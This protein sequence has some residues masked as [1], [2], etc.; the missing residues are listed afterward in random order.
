[1]RDTDGAGADVCE[2]T[3]PVA[4][5]P[6]EAPHRSRPDPF[7]GMIRRNLEE[8]RRSW[9]VREKRIYFPGHR[10]W[11]REGEAF[12]ELL[13][14]GNM[15]HVTGVPFNFASKKAR[16]ILFWEGR[17]AGLPN[18][19]PVLPDHQPWMNGLIPR[20]FKGIWYDQAQRALEIHRY[21]QY[22]VVRLASL[23]LAPEGLGGLTLQWCQPVGVYMDPRSPRAPVEPMVCRHRLCP[24]CYAR[25]WVNLLMPLRKHN[26]GG[27]HR[28][29]LTADLIIDEDHGFLRTARNWA[30]RVRRE[31]GCTTCLSGFHLAPREDEQGRLTVGLQAAWITADKPKR[32]YWPGPCGA[33][34]S[35]SAKLTRRKIDPKDSALQRALR[36]VLPYPT[37]TVALD[38]NQHF[39]AVAYMTRGQRRFSWTGDWMAEGRSTGHHHK[40]RTGRTTADDRTYGLSP[41]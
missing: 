7:E 23:G 19:D 33:I 3:A 11:L 15:W 35:D 34:V 24:W 40:T 29:T 12:P 30:K 13:F 36:L 39:G 20:Q 32:T 21:W 4:E 18:H 17:R 9:Q 38:H 10:A 14:F 31:S 28:C 41:Q 6:A 8:L 37:E 22:T 26:K 2:N 27:L 1:M 16:H 5:Q 25:Q